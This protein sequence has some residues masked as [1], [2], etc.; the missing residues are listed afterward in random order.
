MHLLTKKF[1]PG[2]VIT[3]DVLGHCIVD[4]VFHIGGLKDP[5]TLCFFDQD[6]T[7]TKL[8]STDIPEKYSKEGSPCDEN[9]LFVNAGLSFVD[10][11]NRGIR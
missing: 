7:G 10:L 4:Q 2:S 9:F 1:A 6:P 11:N 5:Q 8:L 3:L